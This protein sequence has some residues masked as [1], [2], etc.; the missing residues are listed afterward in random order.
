[1]EERSDDLPWPRLHPYRD[2]QNPV[3]DMPP[4][5]YGRWAC[6]KCGTWRFF[7][8]QPQ[9]GK[10]IWSAAAGGG[11]M[12]ECASCSFAWIVRAIDNI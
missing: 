8:I 4:Y 6:P 7:S 1:M 3:V 9:Y 10:G 5:S 12:R 2:P 11:L